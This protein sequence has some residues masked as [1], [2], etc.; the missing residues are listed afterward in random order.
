MAKDSAA[1]NQ[2]IVHVSTGISSFVTP[3]M[4]SSINVALPAIGRELMLDAVSLGWVAS[5]S[6][7]SSAMLLL[8]LGRLAD[9]YGRRPFF[10]A[11]LLI[12][13]LASL[14]AALAQTGP[15]LLGARVAQGVAGAMLFSTGVAILTS[16]YPAEKTGWALGINIA[17]TYLGLSL[18]PFLGGILTRY[19]GWRAVFG[20][21]LP[22]S[23]SALILAA[24]MPKSEPAAVNGERFD[25]IGSL[26]YSGGVLCLM[27]GL[28]HLPESY[29]FLLILSG[30]VAILAFLFWE[31]K[32]PGPIL[33]LNL[34]RHNQV[35]AFSNLAALINYSAT[36]A[37]SLLLSLYLQYVKQ[38]DVQTAGIILV[39]QPVVMAVF[40][41]LAGRLSDKIEPRIIASIGMGISALGL[42][43]FVLLGPGTGIGLVIAGL[44]LLG[45]GFALFSA[46]NTNAVMG[47]VEPRIYG[48]A[49]AT[50]GTMRLFGQMLSYNI[51][52]ML[53]SIF[54]GYVQLGP[55]VQGELLRTLRVAFSLYGGLCVAGVFASLARGRTR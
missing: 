16:V 36:A 42:I 54:V 5:A 39:S 13:F 46:P 15:S 7:L 48:I 32:T 9:I 44:L 14:W 31:L 34:F 8:P 33:N 2:L 3:F 45:F 23:I 49:S 11:G 43:L 24:F 19:L 29:A 27:F 4:S 6:L 17:A 40:S 10:A 22:F 53:V 51:A 28:S 38:L 1:K 52:M 20:I 12:Y 26:V 37:V 47:S 50:L 55:Q 35:F 18:G 30:I 41:P 25:L 21:N